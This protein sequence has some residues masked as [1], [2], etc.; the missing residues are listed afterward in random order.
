M[1]PII[2]ELVGGILASSMVVLMV[3]MKA[4][5]PV[6]KTMP[7]PMLT[8]QT[9]VSTMSD[10]RRRSKPAKSRGAV[11]SAR[12]RR[13]AKAKTP[14]NPVIEGPPAAP[15]TSEP[16]AVLE[17]CPSCGL[18]APEHLLAE[19]F[20]GSPAHRNGPPKMESPEV[21]D[22]MADSETVEEDSKQSVRNLLQMLVPPRA[23]GRRHSGRTVSPLATI[24]KD[25]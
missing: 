23:F 13:R 22:T 15:V 19:H 24:V 12:P 17:T 3:F 7:M 21:A 10:R 18:Q 20:M 2:I 11:S 14:I 8:I 5:Y 25:M 6:P 9:P 16:V 4:R 1:D